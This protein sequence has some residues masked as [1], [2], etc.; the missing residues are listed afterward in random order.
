MLRRL[1]GLVYRERRRL[2]FVTSLA[3]LAGFLFYAR[4]DLYIGGFQV[5]ILTGAVYALIIGLV[6]LLIC[7]LL[8]SLRFMI[9]AVAVSRLFLAV[10]VFF[11]PEIGQIIL[12]NPLLTAVI[13]V[14]S[15]ALLSRVMHGRILREKAK[16][17]RLAFRNRRAMRQ[18]PVRLEATP[19][20]HKFVGWVDGRAPIA[21]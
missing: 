6:T 21:A 12:M 16:N 11:V 3:F 13:V 20:Q 5:G 18:Q 14:S 9:D 1:K 10:V 8:P 4:Y 15:G 7:A 19:L 17:W 2:L